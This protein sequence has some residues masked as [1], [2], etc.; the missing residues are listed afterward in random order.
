MSPAVKRPPFLTLR[1]TTPRQEHPTVRWLQEL[2]NAKPTYVR[3]PLKVDGIFGGSTAAEVEELLYRLGHPKPR[4]A[5]GPQALAVLWR[6][7]QSNGLPAD[8]RRRRLARMATGFKRG[9]GISERSWR[10]LHPGQFATYNPAK[11]AA[12]GVQFADMGLHEIP[13]GSNK[14]PTLTDRAL[15]H[16]VDPDF[17]EM[18]YAWC[19]FFFYLCHLMAGSATAKAGLVDG[20]FWPLFCPYILEYARKEQWGHSL[21]RPADVRPGDAVLF[22]FDAN[23]D[24][25]HIGIGMVRPASTVK[26]CDGNTSAGGSQSN[27]GAVMV[28]ERPV[29]TAIAY[30]RINS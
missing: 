21:V 8:W 10:A 1:L 18:G 30:V 23:P 25:D 24:A 15:D 17:A 11:A 29:G 19:A 4:P 9:W 16:G 20:K 27:G 5:I 14:Q 22:N 3:P 12:I 13:A 2:I 26:S 6:W 28:R 7:S